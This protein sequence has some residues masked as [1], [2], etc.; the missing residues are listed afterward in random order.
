[1]LPEAIWTYLELWYPERGL[2]VTAHI[3]RKASGMTVNQAIAAIIY[4]QPGP[5][6]DL[7]TRFSWTTTRG[8]DRYVE[9]LQGLKPWPDDITK[10]TIDER[11]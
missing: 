2:M 5:P 1:M 9:R 4:V 8:S 7:I 3:T 10:I 11:G 6:E